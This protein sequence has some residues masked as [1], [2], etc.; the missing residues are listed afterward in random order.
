MYSCLPTYFILLRF[1][2][3]CRELDI[4][5]LHLEQSKHF[6]FPDP[7]ASSPGSLCTVLT[8]KCR[9]LISMCFNAHLIPITYLKACPTILVQVC[10]YRRNPFHLLMS[11]VKAEI[12]KQFALRKICKQGH[13]GSHCVCHEQGLAWWCPCSLHRQWLTAHNTTEPPGSLSKLP[14]FEPRPKPSQSEALDAGPR[15]L[16]LEA[17]GGF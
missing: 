1:K 13:K 14:V 2:Q 8:N 6:Y 7:F 16:C 15:L 5:H 4:K 11:W 10:L 17:P 3:H 12:L 9:M